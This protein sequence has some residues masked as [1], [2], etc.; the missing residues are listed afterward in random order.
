LA[1]KVNRTRKIDCIP[2]PLLEDI[3][4]NNCVPIIGAGFSMNAILPPNSEMSTWSKLGDYFAGQMPGYTY[5]S[6]LDAI[7]TYVHEYSRTKTIEHLKKRLHIGHARPGKSHLSFANLPFD[8]VITTNYDFLLE[9]AY[10]SVGKSYIPVV[11]EEQ[12]SS[13]YKKFPMKN[14][15]TLII[16]IHGDFHH[17]TRMV[18]TEEDYDLFVD[19]NPLMCTYIANLLITRTPLFIGYSMEDPDFRGIWQIIISRLGKL[20]RNGYTLRLKSSNS[21]VN[22]FARR[23]VKV[24]DIK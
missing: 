5:S 15:E 4:N 17:P 13:S 1:K 12:L 24:I 18:I 23:G 3:S 22:R 21:D 19:K 11:E 8:V 9:K 6:A 14:Y 20:R 10:E 7:S 16:K 2:A